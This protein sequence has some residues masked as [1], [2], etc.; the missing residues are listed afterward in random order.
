MIKVDKVTLDF[1]EFPNFETLVKTEFLNRIETDDKGYV[2]VEFKWYDDKSLIRLYFVLKHLRQMYPKIKLFIYYMPY[3]RMDRSQNGSCFT[4]KYTTEMLNTA[5]CAEDKVYILEP[6]SDVTLQLL[7]NSERINV[8]TPLMKNILKLNPEID[9]ICYPDKGAKARFQDDN[10]ELPVVFCNK[11]R[12]FDTG[13]ITGLELD[14][15]TNVSDKNIL[16]LDDLCSKGGTFYHTANKLKQN[17][18]KDVYLG[19]CHMESTVKYGDIY[20]EY[21]NWDEAKVSPI[22]HIYCLDTMVNSI[23]AYWLQNHSNNLT[24]YDTEVFLSNNKFK[25]VE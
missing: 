8:I 11:V 7:K 22:K 15:D 9:M 3:S 17:G 10:V 5:L 4:L 19:V 14:G 24:M 21:K 12:D 13:E 1:G 16:I 25:E 6:H 23:E 20:A 18:A 2:K